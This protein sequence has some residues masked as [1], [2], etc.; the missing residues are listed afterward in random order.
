M[1]VVSASSSR[2][3]L[4]KEPSAPIFEA[5]IGAGHLHLLSPSNLSHTGDKASC[6]C[7]LSTF[8]LR[9]RVC[10][11]LAINAGYASQARHIR[12][13]PAACGDSALSYEFLPKSPASARRIPETCRQ[14]R[15]GVCVA[16]YKEKHHGRP[17]MGSFLCLSVFAK[18]ICL[19]LQFLS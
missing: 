10:S 12:R 8:R 13:A 16:E 17:E 4:M 2:W 14:P 5:A 18:Q 3:W 19:W 7:Q 11:F 1:A 15:A 6:S 9:P